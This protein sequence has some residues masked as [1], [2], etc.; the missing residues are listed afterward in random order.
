MAAAGS[1]VGPNT[2][3]RGNIRGEGGIEILGRVEGDVTVEG[4]VIIGENSAVRGQVSAARITIAGRVQGDLTGSDAVLVEAGARVVGDLVAPRIGIASG[5]LV[6]GT[7]RTE[8]EAPLAQ[9]SH[10]ARRPG[11]VATSRFASPAA[12]PVAAPSPARVEPAPKPRPSVQ[13]VLDDDEAEAASEAPEPKPMPAEQERH[14]P[15]P[16]VPVIAKGTKAKKKV[17]KA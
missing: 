7:V 10:A 6:R 1:F 3:I 12:R 4:D 17:R 16:V 11:A 2:V 14:A 15:P 8:G 5:A 9:P 13:K